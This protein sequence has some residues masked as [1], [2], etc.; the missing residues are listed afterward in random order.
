MSRS[1]AVKAGELVPI[2]VRLRYMEGVRASVVLVAGLIAALA[3]QALV[4]DLATLGAVTGG[5]VAL[6]AAA[7]LVARRWRTISTGVFGLTLIVDGLFLAWAAYATGGPSSPLRYLILLHLIAVALLASYRTGLKL[8]LWDSLLLLV[9]HYAQASEILHRTSGAGIGIGTPFQ[10]VIE[11][12]AAFWFVAVAT[13]TLTA[14]NERELR[15]RRYDLEALAAMA[16]RLEAVSE[17]GEV[18]DTLLEAMDQTFDF[19]RSVLIG[20]LDADAPALIGAHGAAAVDA[21]GAPPAAGSVLAAAVSERRTRLVDALDPAADP[22]LAALLPGARNLVVIPLS[23]EGQS[24]GAWVGEHPGRLGPRIERRV[25]GMAER[26]ISYGSLALR[27]AWLLE[28]VRRAA[29][30]DGLTGV[31]NRA[32]FDEA[33]RKELARAARREDDVSLLLLDIDHFKRLNDAHG[34]QAGDEVLR[35]V[36]AQLAVACRD[37]D[38]PARYGGEEFAIVLPATPGEEALVV[39]ERLRRA[40]AGTGGAT[41]VTVSVGVATFPLDGP[42]PAALV[43]AADGAMY[44]SKRGGRDRVTAARPADPAELFG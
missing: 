4:V 7:H 10:R 24:F 43:A 3:R 40:I 36:A 44:A 1:T 35:R 31:A 6:M 42:T 37:F 41:A 8:A 20:S 16:T 12:S 39:A 22:W 2:A 18:A 32:S 23:A 5:Y 38:T 30:T 19:H 9:V 14:V 33:L 11:F 17:P 26:F 13:A 21:P 15:R 25:V 34:H 28:T 29:A 27:N